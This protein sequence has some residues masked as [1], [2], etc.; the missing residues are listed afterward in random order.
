MTT[1]VQGEKFIDA[2]PERVWEFLADPD[3]RAAPISVVE[4]W[5]VHDDGSAT[6]HVGLPIP[7]IGKTI[8][9]ETRDVERREGEYVK[10]RG[11]SRVMRVTGEHTLEPVDGGTSVTLTFVVDGRFPGV[12]RFFKRNLERELINLEDALRSELATQG[13]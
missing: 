6:W 11:K 4:D 10:F 2:P 13:E 9:V 12:E 3:K 1:R 7:G 5:T 8:A